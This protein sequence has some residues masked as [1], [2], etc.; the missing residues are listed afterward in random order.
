MAN[1][2]KEY[3]AQ[4]SISYVTSFITPDYL[5]GRGDTDIKVYVDSVLQSTSHYNLNGTSLNFLA[6][7]VP[8]EGQEIRIVRNTSQDARLTDYTDGSLLDAE[9]LDRDAN[10]TFYMAQEAV[11][12]SSVTNTAAGSFYY[13]Q[14]QEPQDV[15]VGTLWYDLDSAPNVLKIKTSDGWDFA[16]PVRASYTFTQ[17]S[18]EFDAG[19]NHPLCSFTT[20]VYTNS[21][22]VFLNGVKLRAASSVANID[23][24][25]DYFYD[26][27]HNNLFLLDITAD[28][29]LTLEV[30]TGGG[31]GTIIIQEGGSSSGGSSSGG[32][33]TLDQETLNDI[34]QAVLEAQG[35]SAAAAAQAGVALGY[36]TTASNHAGTALA[37]AG[38]ALGHANNASNIKDDIDE[39]KGQI[40]STASI[41]SGQASTVSEKAGEVEQDLIDVQGHIQTIEN[42]VSTASGHASDASGFANDASGFATAAS[43]HSTDAQGFASQASDKASEAVQ[44]ANNIGAVGDVATHAQNAQDAAGQAQADAATVAGVVEAVNGSVSDAAGHVSTALGHASDAQQFALSAS[45]H[46]VTATNAKNSTLEAI[47]NFTI[48]TAAAAQSAIDASGF[49][50]AASGH[51]ST[52]AGHASTAAASAGVVESANASKDQALLFKQQAEAAANV[53]TDALNGWAVL[54]N[55]TISTYGSNDTAL[56]SSTRFDIT[57]PNGVKINNVPTAKFAMVVGLDASSPTLEN[58]QPDFG[59][60]NGEQLT[61]ERLGVGQYRVKLG[62]GAWS[63][64]FYNNTADY[65]VTAQFNNPSSGAHENTLVDIRINKNVEYFDVTITSRDDSSVGIDDGEVILFLYEI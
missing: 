65:Q 20:S 38:L 1:S 10:Q 56:I 43:G 33:A 41:I 60:I 42:H 46:A 39:I 14:G 31:D 61:L 35:Y 18:P 7:H 3:T 48:D 32:T 24:D 50:D 23:V 52:A 51:A 17:A 59:Y 21:T 64:L 45:G 4:A 13:S 29:V 11:D 26:Y 19:I 25:G 5:E 2:I 28:D 63:S 22:W 9:T 8:T 27:A 40:D 47:D 12:L 53:S 15:A 16:A 55:N 6:G 54:S 37:Q 57:A 34:N 30:V 49:A 62:T 44:A 36:A 58:T